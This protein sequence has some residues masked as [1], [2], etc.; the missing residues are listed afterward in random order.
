M[1]DVFKKVNVMDGSPKTCK[2]CH[3]E[4]WWHTIEGRWY[5]PGGTTLHVDSCKLRKEHFHDRAMDNAE[6]ARTRRQGS[7]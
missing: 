4:V 2:F 6:Q 5:D 7:R 3:R 1:G